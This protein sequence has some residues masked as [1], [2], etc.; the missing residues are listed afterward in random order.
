MMNLR[1]AGH[2]WHH[3]GAV[4]VW[5]GVPQ[6]EARH[7]VHLYVCNLE[8]SSSK[9]GSQVFGG[10]VIRITHRL[11]KPEGLTLEVCAELEDLL[12][13]SQVVLRLQM[14]ALAW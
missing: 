3:V 6:T 13:H 10:K 8:L 4:L 7:R 5:E 11:L 2:A 1:P 14:Q 12:T 9:Y